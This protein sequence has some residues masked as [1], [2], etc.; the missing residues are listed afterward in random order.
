MVSIHLEM[1]FP[2]FERPNTNSAIEAN[3]L[4]KN[5]YNTE[6]EYKIKQIKKIC[7]DLPHGDL[8]IVAK[9]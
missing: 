7:E 1:I 6:M 2:D 4:L 3:G 5:Q 8:H 9:I